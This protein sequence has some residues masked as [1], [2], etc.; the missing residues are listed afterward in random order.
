[1]YYPIERPRVSIPA[2]WA[3]I[4]T[5]L[6]QFTY[7]QLI[8]KKSSTRQ[9]KLSNRIVLI[10]A[11][12]FYTT[13]LLPAQS[14]DLGRPMEKGEVKAGTLLVR[15]SDQSPM[16]PVRMVGTEVEIKVTGMI[17]RSA[18]TQHF[19]NPT[20]DWLEGI[21]V[22]PLPETAAVDT[23]TMKIGERIIVGEIKERAEAKKLYKD[24]QLL[25][26]AP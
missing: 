24:M 12:F 4:R 8:T 15:T 10:I 23:L 16:R 9:Q 1:M 26:R 2:F 19:K 17:A 21:Y 14:P 3:F 11:L 5:S 13:I 6:V 22:F 18:V 25:F 7:L 20:G